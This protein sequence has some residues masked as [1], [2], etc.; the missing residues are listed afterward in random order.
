MIP[1]LGT[2]LGAGCVFFMRKPL[3]RIAEQALNGFGGGVM[4]AASF[5][6]LLVPAI[7]SSDELGRFAFLP[8]VIGFWLGVIFL[9]V[10]DHYVVPHL[11]AASNYAEGPKSKLS[12]TSM[13]VLAVTVHNIPEGMAVGAIFSGWLNGYEGIS[14]AGA[15]ALSVGI[16]IQN[17]PE[18]TI[19]SMPLKAAGMGKWRAFGA[20]IM[21]GIVE[22][23]GGILTI[24]C[25]AVVIPVLPY[26]LAFAAG[27]MLYVVVE[28]LIPE[29]SEGKHSSVG[30]IS[31]TVGFTMMMALDV[32]FG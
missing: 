20:G 7:E 29:M 9:L 10:I 11:H 1:F 26:F 21:S 27:A 14:L 28:E 18:G 12:R 5:W 23:I 6:S 2:V 19:I 22:P 32:A 30:V 25:A 13:L 17:F 15:L 4:V 3:S 16:A 24:L 31:F 8:A